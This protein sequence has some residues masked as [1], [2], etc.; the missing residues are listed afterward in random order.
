[1]RITFI[2]NLFRI[3]IVVT[4]T[5]LP[6]IKLKNSPKVQILFHPVSILQQENP[7]IYVDRIFIWY[8]MKVQYRESRKGTEIQ[9]VG[10]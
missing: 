5:K 8:K 7:H 3:R 9:E 6:Q 1:M 4:E 10:M 2:I